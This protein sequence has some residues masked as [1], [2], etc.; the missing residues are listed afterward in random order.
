[1]KPNYKYAD[2]V[3]FQMENKYKDIK[4]NK[5][6][7]TEKKKEN[8]QKEEV[9]NNAHMARCLKYMSKYNGSFSVK[10]SYSKRQGSL[11]LRSLCK[12][13]IL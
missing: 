11:Q 2:I 1:M 9:E 6:N 8:S 10:N 12:K 7:E 13:A 4:C 5:F 3:K